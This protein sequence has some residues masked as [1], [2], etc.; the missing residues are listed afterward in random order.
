MDHTFAKE[1]HLVI[2]AL[3]HDRP[4]IINDL[5]KIFVDYQCSIVDSRMTVLGAEFAIIMM[6]SGTWDSVAKLE[7]ALPAITG[8]LGLTTIIKQTQSRQPIQSISYS[9]NVVALDHPGIVHDIANFFS[10]RNIN[11]VD[12]ETGTYSAPHTGTK[13]F[14]INMSI[15]IPAD[16]HLAT[17]REEFMVFCDDRNLDALIE[18]IR[19]I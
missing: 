6:V 12:L 3:G 16:T 11:I 18:P 2:S 14:N 7:N 15:T 4:G 9:V 8:N 5:A 10:R 13:M 1:N 19:S 17:L